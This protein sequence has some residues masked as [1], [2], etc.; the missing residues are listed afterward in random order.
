VLTGLLI[1]EVN[2][3]TLCELGAGGVSMSS[4]SERTLGRAGKIV[5]STCYLLL[6]Y[7]LL[8]AYMAVRPPPSEFLGF[9]EFRNLA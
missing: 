1:A 8:V 9:L 7:A 6:H 4:M 3:N 2:A 5:S